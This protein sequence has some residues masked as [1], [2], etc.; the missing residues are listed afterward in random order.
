M[1]AAQSNELLWLIDN[2]LA[3]PEVRRMVHR[4][5]SDPAIAES[6]VPDLEAMR[7]YVQVLVGIADSVVATKHLG[8]GS[9]G[10][11]RML[12]EIRDDAKWVL[13]KIAPPL[14]GKI[15]DAALATA[16]G[17]K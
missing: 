2:L 5:P 1:S 15:A 4:K 9:E 8:R 16:Q 10:Q 11:V 17:E 14:P 6:I 13:S 12:E 7:K 3:T